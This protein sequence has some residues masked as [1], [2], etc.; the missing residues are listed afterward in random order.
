MTSPTGA[1]SA[2]SCTLTSAT[3]RYPRRPGGG[4]TPYATAVA[5]SSIMISGSN[6]RVTPSSVATGLQ[7]SSAYHHFDRDL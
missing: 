7:P 5:S 6:N 4:P 1:R 3:E 2:V